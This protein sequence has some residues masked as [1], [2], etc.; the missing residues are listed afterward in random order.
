[1]P[2][3]CPGAYEH[4]GRGHLWVRCGADGCTA[5]WYRPRHGFPRPDEPG[6]GQ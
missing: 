6:A 4:P 3:D 2:C 5:T 1:M